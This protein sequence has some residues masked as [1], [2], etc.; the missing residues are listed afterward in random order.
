MCLNRAAT[1]TEKRNEFRVQTD[2]KGHRVGFK[3]MTK[4]GEFPFQGT[5][6]KIPQSRWINERKYRLNSASEDLS[7][8]ETV[9]RYP[10]GFHIFVN[11]SEAIH[12]LES[13]SKHNEVREVYFRKV[14]ARGYQKKHR[15]IVCKEI[16]FIT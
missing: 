3:I 7:F 15:V 9:G 5:G 12:Y 6:G 13:F 2:L 1:E 4:Q 8:N 16:C 14:V 10:T 11:K